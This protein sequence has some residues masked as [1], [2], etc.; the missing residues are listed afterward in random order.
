MAEG[1]LSPGERAA[2]MAVGLAVAAAGAKSPPNPLLN[3]L[4]LGLGSYIAWRGYVG[5][6]PIKAALIDGPAEAGRIA[7]RS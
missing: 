2:Y 4:A 6:C 3:I 1:N 5:Q 7:G